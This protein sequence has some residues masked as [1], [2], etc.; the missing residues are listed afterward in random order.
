MAG[1]R[2]KGII[3]E[4]G[5]DTDGLDKIS[6]KCQLHNQNDPDFPEGCHHATEAGSHQ[7]ESCH[8]EIEVPKGCSHHSWEIL[9]T[10]FM[11]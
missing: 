8:P 11:Y 9:C 3:A 10:Y 7:Q 2:R 5:G 1:D 4:I 6:K